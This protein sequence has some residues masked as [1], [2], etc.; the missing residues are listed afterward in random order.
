MDVI[1]SRS[2]CH[3][4][5]PTGQRPHRSG[6]ALA[7]YASPVDSSPLTSTMASRWVYLPKSLQIARKSGTRDAS[8]SDLLGVERLLCFS[9]WTAR[10]LSAAKLSRLAGESYGAREENTRHRHD[11][12]SKLRRAMTTSPSYGRLREIDCHRGLH[13]VR[14]DGEGEIPNVRRAERYTSFVTRT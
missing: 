3:A 11:S 1:S 6:P 12:L 7:E 9:G 10:R 2:G 4:R 13:G 14:A 8:Y 5:L